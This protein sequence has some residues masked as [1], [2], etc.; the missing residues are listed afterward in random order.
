MIQFDPSTTISSEFGIFGIPNTFENS[1]LILLPVPW[2]VTTSYG[3]GASLGPQLIRHASEQIDLFD[4]ETEKA[5]ENGYHM[6][7]FPN[8][9]KKKNDHFKHLAQDVIALKT[10]LSDDSKHIEDLT[11]QINLACEEMNLWV[12]NESKKI[13][14]AGKLLGL[15]GGDHSTPY[16]AIKALCEFHNSEMGI[17]HIDAHADLRASYQGFTYSHASIMYNVMSSSWRPKQ[18]VQIGIRDF[19]E[20]EFNFSN[21]HPGITTFYDILTKQN[22][23]NGSSW[24]DIASDIINKLPKKVY[25]SFDI[26][27]LEPVLC[28]HTGTPVPGGYSLDQIFFLFNQIVKSGRTI[29]GFDLNEVSTGGSPVDE[30]DEWDGNV[31]ARVLYKLCGWTVLSQKN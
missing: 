24:L 4:I 5:Y 16:G 2:E 29:V 6:L 27:G 10:S 21:Q 15:V 7:E 25:I 23:L 30:A 8:E 26:D 20:D 11:Q 1:K 19:C 12:Y 22:L 13:L 14:D 9:L 3:A 18:L 28:P 17:L 31:G